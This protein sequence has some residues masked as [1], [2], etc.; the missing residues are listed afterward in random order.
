MDCSL[1]GSWL[2]GISQAKILVW[3]AISYSRG[4]SQTRD[5]TWVSHIAGG[6]FLPTEWATR[7]ALIKKLKATFNLFFTNYF[8]KF[9]SFALIHQKQVLVFMLLKEK[10]F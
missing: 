7:E 5:Q 1:P 4:S 9:I 8:K 6:F 3:T 2:H 10:E